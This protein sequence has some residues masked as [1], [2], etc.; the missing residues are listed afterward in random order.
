MIRLFIAGDNRNLFLFEIHHGGM[1]TPR[2]VRTYVDGKV[3]YINLIDI[4]KF[5]IRDLNDM[6]IELGYRQANVMYNH[7]KIRPLINLDHG[8]H[9]LSGDFDVLELEKYVK[10]N[11]VTIAYIKH[12]STMVESIFDIAKEGVIIEELANNIPSQTSDSSDVDRK[13]IPMCRRN[14]TKE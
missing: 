8:L 11:K 10:D 12:G 1:F 14:M 13:L 7:F 2:P 5:C 4:D 9:P 6:V 3:S